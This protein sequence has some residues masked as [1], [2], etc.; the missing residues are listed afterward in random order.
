VERAFGPAR[1]AEI[2]FG[3]SKGCSADGSGLVCYNSFRRSG[4]TELW[5]EVSL[6]VHMLS[7]NPGIWLYPV[8]IIEAGEKLAR[9]KDSKIKTMKTS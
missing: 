2:W 7:I 3:F 8:E 9:R 4:V 5:I 1:V 6:A